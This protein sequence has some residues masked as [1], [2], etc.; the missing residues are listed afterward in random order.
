MWPWPSP[1]LPPRGNWNFL[2]PLRVLLSKVS[3]VFCNGLS[4]I[5]RQRADPYQN[6]CMRGHRRIVWF[7]LQAPVP[8][9]VGCACASW[10]VQGRKT[11]HHKIGPARPGSTFCSLSCSLQVN[12]PGAFFRTGSPHSGGVTAGSWSALALPVPCFSV[13]SLAPSVSEGS[14][15]CHTAMFSGLR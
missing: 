5:P 13:P 11:K 2:A 12:M 8:I 15:C 9:A 4:L 10:G 7:S 1:T 3:F 6:V 14:G